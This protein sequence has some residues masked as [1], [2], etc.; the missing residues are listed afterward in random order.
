MADHRASSGFEHAHDEVHG[1]IAQAQ[2][3]H[4]ARVLAEK[5]ARDAVTALRRSVV[6]IRRDG[7]EAWQ[8][9][10]LRPSDG[11][12][13]ADIAHFANLPPISGEMQQVLAR[14]LHDVARAV[15]D[16]RALHGARRF[17]SG[18]SKRRAAHEAEKYLG[19][20]RQWAHQHGIPEQ[21]RLLGAHC[22]RRVGNVAVGEVLADWTGFTKLLGDLGASPVLMD[23]HALGE[24]PAALEAVDR[25]PH[26]YK[27][28]RSMAIAAGH[29]TRNQDVRRV[30]AAMPVERL[31][32][33]TTGKIRTDPLRKAGLATVLQV[34]DSDR[35]LEQLPGIGATT[36]TRI[37]GA[38]RTL[39]QVSYDR[40]P[41]RL[42]DRDRADYRTELL[43]RLR[44]LELHRKA[45][46]GTTDY[47]RAA[48]LDALAK[49][50]GRN[51]THLVVFSV[52]PWPV[53]DLWSSVEE[54]CRR[55]RAL[56]R[57]TETT[58]SNPWPEF[59]NRPADFV[60]MLSDLHLV[61]EDERKARGDLPD[62][63]V[64]S[65]RETE[66][67]T[68]FLS[69]ALRGYQ[70]FGAR[71]ALVQRKVVI[72]D[73]MGLGKTVEALAVL[74]HLHARGQRHGLVICPAAVVTNWMREIAEKSKLTG[75][76]V[77]GP[78]RIDAARAWQRDAGVAVTTYETL[79]WLET[80]FINLPPLSC[81]VVDEAHYIKN[82]S[83]LRSRRSARIVKSSDRAVLLTG[84]PLENRID[85]FRNLVSYLR[86]DLVVNASELTPRVFR[87]QVAPVYL[88]RNQ[89]DV[90]TE[91]PEL[92]EVNEWVPMT[93]ADK[94][95]Y[96]EAVGASNFSAMRQAA[97]GP[98]NSSG[99][100][101]R[102]LQIVAE[103]EANGRRA[104][105][106]SYFRG[107]L[108]EVTNALPQQKMFGPL[109]GGVSAAARQ[110]IIDKFSSTTGGAVL[111]AQIVAGGV[112]LNIQA[113]SV[114]VICE[115]Q[116]KPTTEWQA[117]ARA[118]RMGQLESVQV[119]RLLSEEGVD[120]R[121]T[122]I[123]ARK[124]T[125]FEG[126]ARIS[127]SAASAPEAVDISEA[128]IAEQVVAA[129]RKRL[130]PA[131]SA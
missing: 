48:E 50:L 125:L 73:E 82:P 119:H 46:G 25:A 104:I 59:T 20:Y 77:H 58:L 18:G 38:A 33:A 94:R 131:E 60:A 74:A 121:V 72:G 44:A 47:D 109:H 129:E 12:R 49:T 90:L 97:M 57:A 11:A 1:W 79:E 102:L 81:V 105:V 118:H 91:L 78:G 19:T 87:R 6:T 30:L 111:V 88:R 66:L 96:R 92:V 4:S 110:D 62:E 83:A 69:A 124:R 113:A 22:V 45:M 55:G 32:E 29:E 54:V 24:L 68:E 17:L 13:L 15:K 42:D 84:T 95:K 36:A 34:L 21:L 37:R 28:L 101:Q 115:P 98:P 63:I 5:A 41:V 107:V 35:R 86:P 114:V 70:S 130:F 61:P 56:S 65:I 53:S 7:R 23:A 64:R 14:L 128:E 40:T 100:M 31:R 80:A 126:F 117:I 2:A 99:K 122:E 52:G 76:R 71:F 39:W 93:D 9:V 67:D 123:L 127:E 75:H 103:A 26:E 108:A 85:E 51:V 89:E 120:K 27:R 43:R 106:F 16:R 8:V 112:G 3:V 116:L 10:P